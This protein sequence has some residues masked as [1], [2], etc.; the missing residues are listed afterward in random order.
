[1]SLFVGSKP[2]EV[3]DQ[4]Y[5]DEQMEEDRDLYRLFEKIALVMFFLPFSLYADGDLSHNY[6]PIGVMFG[7]ASFVYFCSILFMRLAYGSDRL[8]RYL[9]YAADRMGLRV[10]PFIFL[11]LC[12][13]I[14]GI[15][16]LHGIAK[17]I[18]L[19]QAGTF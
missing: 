16:S 14:I 12:L 5:D 18:H 2:F 19:I 11:H 13:S 7:M 10:K 15:V 17:A 8:N 3:D 1:L 6:L 4:H 9:P